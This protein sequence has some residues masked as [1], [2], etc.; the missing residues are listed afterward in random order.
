MKRIATFIFALTLCSQ[1][2]GQYDDHTETQ[3]LNTELGLDGYFSASNF[4]GTF[5]LGLKYGFVF[6]EEKN[7][8][9]GPAFRLQR[10]WSNFLGQNYAY[11]ILGGGAFFHAR[12][13]NALFLGTE[14][15]FLNSPINYNVFKPAKK[16]VP[17]VFIG[18][19][20]SQRFDNGIRVNLG[21]F[22]D[23]VNNLNS[24]F[25]P[26]YN[27]RKENGVIIPVLYRLALFIPLSQSGE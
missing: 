14:I 24:P 11:N 4:G 25:R 3:K 13:Y 1:T 18:G 5:V 8:I 10:S 26:Y 9:A 6:G 7:L 21:I 19:G 27:A 22:Y 20:Y 15:E 23:V 17:T 16:F 2:F 12:F